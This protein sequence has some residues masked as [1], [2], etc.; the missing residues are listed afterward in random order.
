MPRGEAIFLNC[1]LAWEWSSS[2]PGITGPSLRGSTRRPC[3][4]RGVVLAQAVVEELRK[5]LIVLPPV[6]VIERLC[7]EAMTRAQRK[8][9]AL[10]I[11]ELDEEQRTKIDRLLE[12]REGSPYR[13]AWLRMPPGAPTPRRPWTYRAAECNPR[14]C[15][16]A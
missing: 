4:P 13:L 9:F 15:F 11:E 7:A 8:V 16:S 5:R 1:C 12:Q 14:S 10:L 6:A 3:E 2:G